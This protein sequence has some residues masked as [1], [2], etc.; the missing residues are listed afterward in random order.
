MLDRFAV[1]FSSLASNS[2]IRAVCQCNGLTAAKRRSLLIND[3]G[4]HLHRGGDDDLRIGDGT[5]EPL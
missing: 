5:L 2:P 4:A 3:D 1:G